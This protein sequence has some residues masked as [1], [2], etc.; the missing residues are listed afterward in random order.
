MLQVH[1]NGRGI[2]QTDMA[3]SR[4]FGLPGMPERVYLLNGELSLQGTPGQGT[5]LIVR[6]PLGQAPRPDQPVL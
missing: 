1:D 6:I 4:S 5:N 3:K 2:T